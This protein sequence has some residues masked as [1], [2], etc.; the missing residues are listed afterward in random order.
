M[1]IEQTLEKLYGMKLNGMAEALSEQRGAPDMT[2]LDFEER[3]GLLVE[4]QWLPALL[5]NWEF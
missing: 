4:R 5:G 3:F 2:D 1:L